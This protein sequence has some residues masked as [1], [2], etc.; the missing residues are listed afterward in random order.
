MRSIGAHSGRKWRLE[1]QLAKVTQIAVAAGRECVKASRAAQSPVPR[2]LVA[3]LC[4]REE[5]V[6]R[7]KSE[8]SGKNNKFSF[9]QGL[10]D[11]PAD[12]GGGEGW[13][14]LGFVFSVRCPWQHLHRDTCMHAQLLPSLVCDQSEMASE[15]W[16][17]SVEEYHPI[18]STWSRAMSQTRLTSPGRPGR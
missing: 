7:K 16:S 15:E 11:A 2:S 6:Q 18:F 8:Q 5:S 13:A 1:V 9:P 3:P 4:P 10:V 14:P 17:Y 12:F